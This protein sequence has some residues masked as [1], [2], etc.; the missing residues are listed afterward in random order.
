MQ[1]R[2]IAD[3]QCAALLAAPPWC[4]DAPFLHRCGRWRPR[5][6]QQTGI[7]RE[8]AGLVGRLRYCHLLAPMFHAFVARPPTK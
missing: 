3:T 1:A 6:E 7:R 5:I 2:D 4:G 8:T